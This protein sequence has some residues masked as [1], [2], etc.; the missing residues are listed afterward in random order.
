[1]ADPNLTWGG[2]QALPSR[3]YTCGFCGNLI[4]SVAGFPLA[5][6]TGGVRA[7]IYICPHCGNPTYFD[8]ASGGKQLPGVRPGASVA[9]LPKDIETA[10]NE[11]RDCVAASAYTAA[12][13]LCRKLLMHLAVGCGAEVGLNFKAYV[14]Y[15]GQAGRGPIWQAAAAAGPYLQGP[16]QRKAHPRYQFPQFFSIN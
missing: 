3:S 4:A 14:E 1:M 7:A 15:L 6:R 2:A 12:A 16:V 13:M 10:Y 9:N 8:F 11:A 5:V